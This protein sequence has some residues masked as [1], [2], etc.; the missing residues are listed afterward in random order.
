MIGACGITGVCSG[1]HRNNHA[2]SGKHNSLENIDAA[3]SLTLLH[4]TE[5]QHGI[6]SIFNWQ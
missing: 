5:A 6:V 2:H 3:L 4:V 1:K